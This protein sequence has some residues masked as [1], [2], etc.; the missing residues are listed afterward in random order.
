LLV[1]SVGVIVLLWNETSSSRTSSKLGGTA[2]RKSNKGASTP[3]I[4]LQKLGPSLDH[5][6]ST[7][8]VSSRHAEM[9]ELR[10]QYGGDPYRVFYAFDPRRT[11]ILLLGGN[12]GG[13]DRWYK[14][15]V[16]WAD[17]LFDEHLAQLKTEGHGGR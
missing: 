11:A 13:D 5:P 8:I 14:K 9:R 10:V 3:V 17:Q 12:K 7:K 16:R 2:W 15:F 6:Y 1:N 4:L